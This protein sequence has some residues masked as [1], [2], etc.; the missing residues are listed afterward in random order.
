MASLPDPIYTVQ[1]YLAR[2]AVAVGKS[3]FY[4]GRI[5]AMAGGSVAHNRIAGNIYFRL[6]LQLDGKPCRPN[7]SDVLVNADSLYTYPDVSVVCPPIQREPGPIETLRN[8]IVI[9]EVLSSSTERYD[10][11]VKLSHY[12]RIASVREILLVQ[13]DAAVV[14]QYRRE[15][16]G[17]AFVMT[18]G[19]EAEVKLDCIDCKLALS[20]IYA[21]VEFPANPFPRVVPQG[22]WMNQQT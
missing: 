3:E 18:H 5:Y 11:N 8:P 1:E 6:A 10:R 7:T 21:D 17:W 16:S 13:Q 19:L 4:Q 9:V 2:E 22:P 14:E 12:Q 20:Q 15:G